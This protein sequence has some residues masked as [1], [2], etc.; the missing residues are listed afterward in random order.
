MLEF[1]VKGDV[2]EI[3]RH[4]SATSQR[5]IP[6]AT[7]RGLTKTVQFVAEKLREELPR[8]FDRP[9]RFTMNAFFIRPA[10]KAR[11]WAEVKI[12]DEAFKG[13]PAI[14]YLAPGI[15][16]GARRRKA[17]ENLLERAGVL[18]PGWVT[19]PGAGAELD[20]YGNMKPSQISQM[21]SDLSARRD[22]LQNIT[23]RSKGRRLRS[24]TKRATFYFSTHPGTARTAHL[25]AGIYKRSHFGFGAAIKPVLIFVKSARY[26]KRFDFYRIADQVGRARWPIEFA[27]AMREALWTAR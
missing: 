14:K 23:A 18:P 7:A 13:T 26:R 8:V 11:L 17:F 20:G 10:T 12:K 3:T 9:T 21:L 1:N 6:Y 22:P 16:G 4:L 27:L 5:H 15:F 19:V 24:R 2:R 25:R